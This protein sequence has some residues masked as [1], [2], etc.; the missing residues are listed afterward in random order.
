MVRPMPN[1]GNIDRAQAEAEIMEALAPY[2]GPSMA[3]SAVEAH[4]TRLRIEGES[5]SREQLGQLVERLVLGLR[6]FVGS[7]K[8]DAIA[9]E[10][11]AAV[12]EREPA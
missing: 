3:R 4:G 6:I 12:G 10:L 9:L 8:S 11:L 2:I 1:D 5:L 7:R